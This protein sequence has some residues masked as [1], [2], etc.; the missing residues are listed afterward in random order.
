MAKSV[1]VFKQVLSNY[2]I[3]I[4]A[5]TYKV[6]VRSLMFVKLGL[7]NYQIKLLNKHVYGSVKNWFGNHYKI[8]TV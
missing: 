7:S 5:K 2:Q 4:Q 6:I 1:I 3:S 8:R